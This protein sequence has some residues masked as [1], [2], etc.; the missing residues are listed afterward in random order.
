MVLFLQ[1]CTTCIRQTQQVLLS[2]R[3]LLLKGYW[4]HFYHRPFLFLPFS[5]CNTQKQCYFMRYMTKSSN[6]M[7]NSI[8]SQKTSITKPHRELV[9]NHREHNVCMPIDSI[10][11]NPHPSFPDIQDDNIG[12]KHNILS[13]PHSWLVGIHST[14]CLIYD[15]SDGGKEIEK[16]DSHPFSIYF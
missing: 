13:S 15:F 5:G 14:V 3:E 11:H 4:G 9:Y 6:T 16:T 1:E 12:H 2:F 10:C 8:L 7:C